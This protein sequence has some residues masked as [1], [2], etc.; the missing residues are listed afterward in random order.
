MKA[1]ESAASPNSSTAFDAEIDLGTNRDGGG[2]SALVAGRCKG[3]IIQ[4]RLAENAE[5]ADARIFFIY[6]LPFVIFSCRDI[7]L[8]L[9]PYWT[10]LS[11]R[12][13]MS[14]EYDLVTDPPA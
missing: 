13:R 4:V 1:V 14:A 7:S 12:Y 5:Q 11:S 2:I 10:G 6:L 9:A 8:P 3:D